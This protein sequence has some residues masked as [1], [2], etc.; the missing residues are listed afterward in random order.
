MCIGALT[1]GLAG[2]L[3]AV[4]HT[5]IP[6]RSRRITYLFLLIQILIIYDNEVSVIEIT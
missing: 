3:I 5:L 2:Q 1:A 6:T 4:A